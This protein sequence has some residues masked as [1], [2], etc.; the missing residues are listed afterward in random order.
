MGRANIA[1]S[2]VHSATVPSLD[3]LLKRYNQRGR[4]N[5]YRSLLLNGT[6]VRV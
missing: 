4:R 1:S 2:T 3:A 5:F 6:P